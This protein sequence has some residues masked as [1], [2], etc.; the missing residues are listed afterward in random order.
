MRF[1]GDPVIGVDVSHRLLLEARQAG[2]VVC[3]R[4]PGLA[5][6]RSAVIDRIVSVGLL[7]LIDDHGTFFTE[8]ARVAMPAVIFWW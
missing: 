5:W 3:A 1:V 8:A 6:V 4:L 7:D 2:P